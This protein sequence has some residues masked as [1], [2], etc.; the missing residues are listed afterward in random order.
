MLWCQSISFS[1]PSYSYSIAA[2]N[3]FRFL[4]RL[5]FFL[6]FFVSTVSIFTSEW[7]RGRKTPAKHEWEGGRKKRCYP[8]SV[9]QLRFRRNGSHTGRSSNKRGR[10]RTITLTFSLPALDEIPLPWSVRNNVWFQILF[11]AFESVVRCSHGSC[12]WLTCEDQ[13]AMVDFD[14]VCR[15][16]TSTIRRRCSTSTLSS[17]S[18]LPFNIPADHVNI[19]HRS[20]AF[21]RP[22]RS[23]TSFDRQQQH[24]DGHEVLSLTARTLPCSTWYLWRTAETR[25]HLQDRLEDAM[26]PADARLRW[27]RRWQTRYQSRR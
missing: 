4:L 27:T 14:H 22:L 24:S 26:S 25:L 9:L 5:S 20:T 7:M 12:P 1:S 18:S 10:E 11:V 21:V 6:S 13:I 2:G 16:Y 19:G 17:S 15:L 8:R 23:A 3:R